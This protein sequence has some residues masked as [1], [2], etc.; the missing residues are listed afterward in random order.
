MASSASSASASR[1]RSASS[2][3][4]RSSVDN[5][6]SRNSQASQQAPAIGHV[7]DQF[8]RRKRYHLN[9]CRR[10]DELVL[11]SKLRLLVKIHDVQFVPA[12]QML[13]AQLGDVVDGANRFP[14]MSGYEQLELIRGRGRRNV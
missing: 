10:C 6:P 5:L 14:R 8:S 11:G 4:S 12:M 7:S 9:E 1:R 13:L 2:S 3:E